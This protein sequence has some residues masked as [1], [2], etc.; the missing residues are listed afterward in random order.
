MV[1]ISA[2]IPGVIALPH[3]LSMTVA[4][5]FTVAGLSDTPS[6]TRIFACRPSTAVEEAGC[7]QNI[8]ARLSRR[9]FRRPVTD[10]ETELLFTHYKEGQRAGGF[11]GGIQRVVQ[12]ILASPN[13]VFRFERTPA[14]ATGTRYR[15]TDLELASR[16]SFFLWSS[17]P[18]E[19]LIWQTAAPRRWQTTSRRNGCGCRPSRRSIP[20][21]ASTPTSL[22]TWR[23]R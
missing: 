7:A 2:G 1:D 8:I 6:R 18:D 22:A 17:G 15:I 11:E 9:A 12:A 14:G 20:T 4:G 3:L 19:R 10:A 5:P 23:S 16:L 13:F 21:A